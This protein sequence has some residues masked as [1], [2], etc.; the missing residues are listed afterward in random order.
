MLDAAA[1]AGFP[2]RDPMSDEPSLSPE[3]NE[4]AESPAEDISPPRKGSSPRGKKAAKRAK[5]VAPEDAPPAAEEVPAEPGDEIAAAPEV[6]ETPETEGET[7]GE[8][9]DP[10]VSEGG[11]AG[12]SKRKRRR[13]KKGG[14]QQ[15]A[16]A[17]PAPHAANE[18]E[19]GQ[20]PASAPAPLP[21]PKHD[22]DLVAK[23]AWKIYLAEI[24]EE[25]VALVGDNDARELAR[26]CFRLSEIFLD[27][28]SRRR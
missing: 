15:S 10:A 2:R 6:E 17:G 11:Q 25:G 8:W 28:Q 18:G 13:K 3:T 16:E 20:A 22:S 26:R 23:H 27:E 1:G 7:T 21:R 19:N 14:Q 12:G 4:A 9:P 5:P 24:S